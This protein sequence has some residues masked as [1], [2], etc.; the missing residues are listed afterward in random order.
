MSKGTKLK[1]I[2]FAMESAQVNCARFCEFDV[3]G[4][5]EK[6]KGIFEIEYLNRRDIMSMGINKTPVLIISKMIF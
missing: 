1:S 4:V 6:K 3:Y 5:F 2:Y